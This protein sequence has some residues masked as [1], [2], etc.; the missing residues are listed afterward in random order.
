MKMTASRAV[1]LTLQVP[2]CALPTKTHRLPLCLNQWNTALMLDLLHSKDSATAAGPVRQTHSKI[3]DN[4]KHSPFN[5]KV[6]LR[7]GVVERVGTP[8]LFSASHNPRLPA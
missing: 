1:L 4:H 2:R 8:F 6:A 3:V 7:Y 5:T